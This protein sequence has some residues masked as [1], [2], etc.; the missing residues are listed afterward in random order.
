MIDGILVI[1]LVVIN[2]VDVGIF[3]FMYNSGLFD[4]Y[5]L[6][7]VE[8]VKVEDFFKVCGCF[9]CFEFLVNLVW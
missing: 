2:I 7:K 6:D 9:V 4:C 3:V 5:C 8:F 1:V